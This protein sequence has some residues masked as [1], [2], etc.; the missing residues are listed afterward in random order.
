MNG[1]S[2]NLEQ[3]VGLQH[4][5]ISVSGDFL[6]MSDLA[7]AYGIK[8]ED[9]SIFLDAIGSLESNNNPDAIQG[10]DTNKPGRGKY[11]WEIGSSQG[12]WTRTNRAMLSLPKELTPQ[13]LALEW[14]K[15]SFIGFDQNGKRSRIGDIDATAFSED[16]QDYI[17]ATNILL[18]TPEVFNK[19]AKTKDKGILIDWWLDH[20]W[21]G[22]SS[23][24]DIKKAYAIKKLRGMPDMDSGQ[25]EFENFGIGNRFY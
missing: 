8:E 4:N 11:Q 12:G 7:D 19:W 22:D 25:G 14:E 20:H 16:E 3:K 24:R 5:M 21:A 23:Q 6:S 15:N 1:I 17:Q 13:K 9:M 2:I 18:Q 10:G